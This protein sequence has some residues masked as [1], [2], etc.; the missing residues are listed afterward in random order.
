MNRIMVIML[1][2]GTGWPC[3][4]MLEHNDHNRSPHWGRPTRVTDDNW[5]FPRAV[6][7]SNYDSDCQPWISGNGERLFFVTININGPPRPG[8]VGSWDIYFS[9]W[10][11]VN[12]CW[13]EPVSAGPYVNT[14]AGERRPCSTYDGDTIFFSRLGDIYMAVWDGNQWVD[15]VR[16]PPPVNTLYDESNPALS[17][18]G[19]R[20]YFDSNRP[21]GGPGDTDIWVVRRIG[22][23]FDSLT[24]LGIPVNTPDKET[25]PFESADKMRLY[26]SNFGGGPRLEGSYGGPDIYVAHWTPSGWD[27]VLLVEAPINCDLVACTAYESPDGERLYIASE[28]WEGSFG[29]EDIWMAVKRGNLSI[30]IPRSYRNGWIK[31]G[32][33]EDA[34]YVY[35]LAE[36]HAGTIYAATACQDTVPFGMVFRTTDG[37]TN[38][39]RTAELPG[40]MVVYSI[41]VKGDTIYAGTYPEGDVFKSTDG[42]N[43]WQNTAE[44]PGARAVRKVLIIQDG[45]VLAGV[46]ASDTSRECKVFRSTDGGSS[47]YETI[48]IDQ[49][50][51]SPFKFLYQTTDG[52]IYAGGWTVSARIWRSTDNG[53]HWYPLELM[54]VN[55]ATSMDGFFQD[56]DG[57]LYAMGWQHH[58][59]SGGGGYVYRS[60]DNGAT[61]DTTAKIRHNQV[62]A[63][64][65]YCL[66]Q[67]QFGSLYAGFQPG[68]DSVVYTSSD[69]G[70]SWFFTGPLPG[71]HEALCLLFSS[72]SVIC[73]GTTPNGDVFKYYPT[74]IGE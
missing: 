35:D 55:T 34:I 65:V 1:M 44:I 52:S 72:D 50:P 25:R 32:E 10:D 69:G 33:L 17:Y 8:Y 31:T 57:S 24:N 64:R 54:P 28:S 48:F 47:W 53:E 42:G 46:S 49:A 11:S 59:A 14:V 15:T 73:A 6:E 74:A 56:R 4:W 39:A 62:R 41:A 20:L 43:N 26:F 70:N 61:W 7:V 40:A 38:W 51:S 67:D 3:G 12:Q 29:G 45:S 9:E 23:T 66:T 30:P 21:P 13:G 36:N 22:S 5:S 2:V 68:P 58:H 37:G 27:S 18:D 63:V 19:R 71:S 60:T 16:L